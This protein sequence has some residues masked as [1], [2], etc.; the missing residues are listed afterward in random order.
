M[1]L[2]NIIE[3][4]ETQK[5]SEYLTYF[6]MVDE[7]TKLF[8]ISLMSINKEWKRKKA[9]IDEVLYSKIVEALKDFK[10]YE[11]YMKPRLESNENGNQWKKRR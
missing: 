10:S 6:L 5:Q 1:T 2:N 4:L 7:K 3:L 11:K 9:T 8:N